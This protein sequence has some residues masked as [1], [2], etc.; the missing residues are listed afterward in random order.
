[1]NHTTIVVFTNGMFQLISLGIHTSEHFYF[2]RPERPN[3]SDSSC[4]CPR[5][6]VLQISK[7]NLAGCYT[8]SS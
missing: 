7:L 2:V 6:N 3:V 1:M 4:F 5:K 8:Y